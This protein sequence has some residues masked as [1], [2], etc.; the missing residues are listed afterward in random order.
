MGNSVR[1]IYSKAFGECKSL[2]SI[3][4][5][6][7]MAPSANNDAFENSYIE[8]VTLYVPGNSVNKYKSQEP[9]S[10]FGQ[11]IAIPGS[12]K[13]TLT[14]LLDGQVYKIYQLVAG[15]TITPE[16]TPTKEGYTFTGWSDI[17]STMPAH[18]VTVTGSFERHYDVGN[19]V[20]LVNLI[21]TGIGG[22]DNLALYDVN[23]D[24]KLNIGDLILVVR[25][26]LNS[27]SKSAA[28][29]AIVDMAVP[30]LSQ[31][32]AAQ[33]VLNV[34]N[35]ISE[36]DISLVKGV[37]QTHQMIC[38]Q[39][40]PGAYAVVIYSL[41]NSLFRPEE[42]GIIEVNTENADSGDLTIQDVVLAK[43]NGETERFESMPIV[44]V[45]PDVERQNVHRSVYD[46]KG[47]KQNRVE[48][49]RKG[50]YIE[51]GKKVVVR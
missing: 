46:L 19:V 37:S 16:P 4:C 36:Q 51:N 49:L 12:T 7:E 26:V 41:T 34:P 33:F 3:T 32:S 20:S 21:L 15:V 39:I 6:A 29:R 38:R 5:L 1:T 30:D 22:N 23:N 44:T 27:T 45:I 13:Y 47:L 9:W 17:P 18:D 42:G 48:G 50:I 31:Y 25:S 24:G 28:T 14:Y 40:E 11:I 43:P 8:Y 10:K 2:E 35:N